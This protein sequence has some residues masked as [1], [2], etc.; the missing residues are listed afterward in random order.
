MLCGEQARGTSVE[1][2]RALGGMEAAILRDAGGCDLGAAEEVGSHLQILETFPKSSTGF[3]DRWMW[4]VKER[5]ESG[6]SE[7]PEGRGAVDGVG[8][9]QVGKDQE[10]SFTC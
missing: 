4:S 3:P 7:P 8:K 10:C 9:L 1:V 5:E 6:V 2:E